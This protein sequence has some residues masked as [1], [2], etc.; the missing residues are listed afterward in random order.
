[1]GQ[2]VA[3]RLLAALLLLS[4]AC[5]GDAAVKDPYKV[6]GVDRS[7]SAEARPVFGLSPPRA[8]RIRKRL[9][10][11]FLGFFL[12]CVR[13]VLRCRSI[14][15]DAAASAHLGDKKGAQAAGAAVPPGQEPGGQG[16]VPGGAVCL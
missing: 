16:E 10:Q 1:M 13:K 9:P 14:R 2:S 15:L 5:L 7:S 11:Y 12:F 4:A 3:W 6:L 8:W